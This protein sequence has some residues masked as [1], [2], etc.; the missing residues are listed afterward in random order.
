MGTPDPPADP[1]ISPSDECCAL[2]CMTVW[3]VGCE[4]PSGTYSAPTASESICVRNCTPVPWTEVIPDNGWTATDC[5]EGDCT[6]DGETPCPVESTTP[7]AGYP[8]TGGPCTT[9]PAEVTI[10]IPT[11]TNVCGSGTC[12]DSLVVPMNCGSGCYQGS[13][14]CP[15]LP[16]LTLATVILQYLLGHWQLEVVLNTFP[17]R[18]LYFWMGPTDPFDPVGAYTFSSDSSDCGPTPPTP[19]SASV[20]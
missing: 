10:T 13:L 14:T 11:V 19:G 1:T 15:S 8:A 5:T 16:P 12:S 20:A 9:Y 18:S 2:S 7:P 6:F 17:N 3:G 4:F